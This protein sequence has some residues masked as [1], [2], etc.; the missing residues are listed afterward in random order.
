MVTILSSRLRH[1]ALTS[2]SPQSLSDRMPTILDIV[3]A[4]LANYTTDQ[5][6][7]VGSWVRVVSIRSLARLVAHCART[8]SNSIAPGQLDIAVS[9][10]I[11]LG[12]ER[13]D[14]VR[15]ASGKALAELATNAF[16]V[17]QGSLVLYG[18]DIFDQIK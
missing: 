11:K 14:S 15:E 8:G 5:R 12:V 17:D 1:I 10:L 7:D 4:G 16:L 6:G 2:P 13:L 3:L 18:R 9:L